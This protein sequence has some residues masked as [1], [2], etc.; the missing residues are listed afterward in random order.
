MLAKRVGAAVTFSFFMLG[1]AL[2]WGTDPAEHESTTSKEPAQ[3]RTATD[4]TAAS[5]GKRIA[6]Q[7]LSKMP[8]PMKELNSP[9]EALRWA[10]NLNGV[11]ST[12]NPQNPEPYV[13]GLTSATGGEGFTP[14]DAFESM[15]SYVTEQADPNQKSTNFL[16]S[17]LSPDRTVQSKARFWHLMNLDKED[18]KQLNVFD[19]ERGKEACDAMKN[20]E[21]DDL[22]KSKA[23]MAYSLFQWAPGNLGLEAACEPVTTRTDAQL[24]AVLKT[25]CQL[26]T[27][28]A[29]KQ[30]KK[31]S[32]GELHTMYA[33]FNLGSNRTSL[34]KTGMTAANMIL[35]EKT[36]EERAKVI[37]ELL[38]HEQLSE[39]SP[40]EPSLGMLIANGYF[41]DA[42]ATEIQ[43]AKGT[44][45]S[46]VGAPQKLEEKL[47]NSEKPTVTIS[48]DRIAFKD[49]NGKLFLASKDY[50]ALNQEMEKASKAGKV[51]PELS[52]KVF[53]S[54]RE[55]D[56]KTG[57]L[58]AYTPEKMVA[59]RKAAIAAEQARLEAEPV[60]PGE[61]KQT[62]WS[63]AKIW[64]GQKLRDSWNVEKIVRDPKMGKDAL[65]VQFKHPQFAEGAV[66]SWTSGPQAGWVFWRRHNPEQVCHARPGQ[67]FICPLQV[68]RR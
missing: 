60:K 22:V 34:S 7:V 40:L 2:A 30:S 63:G 32:L 10:A 44:L 42:I 12:R 65:L 41:P 56:P 13:R 31:D 15:K 16:Q 21:G 25:A 29:E 4:K 49:S 3:A 26:Q 47:K 1:S 8:D 52:A 64:R 67:N 38:D 57:A 48:D 35:D 54:L 62:Q 39:V 14:N 66:Y 43:K 6:R 18:A 27:Q 19:I 17:W 68:A 45:A 36:P 58:T 46:V 33:L 28:L 24:R 53:S 11:C 51:T 59:D 55:V 61:E 50:L 9:L 37:K 20:V 23:A 5:E